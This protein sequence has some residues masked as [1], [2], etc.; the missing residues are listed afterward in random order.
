MTTRKRTRLKKRLLKTA[1]TNKK[2]TANEAAKPKKK[3]VEKKEKDSTAQKAEQP[4]E[5]KETKNTSANEEL[6]KIPEQPESNTEQT[7]VEA[8]TTPFGTPINKPI[9]SEEIMQKGQN[10]IQR[11]ADINASKGIK[12]EPPTE[13]PTPQQISAPVRPA[14]AS[15][16]P[17]LTP[18]AEQANLARITKLMNAAG[19]KPGVPTKTLSGPGSDPRNQ[20][21][22]DCESIHVAMTTGMPPALED[23]P[24]LFSP[25]AFSIEYFQNQDGEGNPV[26]EIYLHVSDG[27]ET[28]RLPEEGLYFI[29]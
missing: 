28:R 8:P 5:P 13:K 21:D 18:A 12:I 2:V 14:P 27:K 15:E 25:Y 16:V 4:A 7:T 19:I 24:N 10:N 6:T 9:T 23:L 26:K 17:D 29:R 1:K 3:P 22:V 11:M 20:F